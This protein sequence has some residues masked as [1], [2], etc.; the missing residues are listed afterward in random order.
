[1]PALFINSSSKQSPLGLQAGARG[2]PRTAPLHHGTG[3][4]ATGHLCPLPYRWLGAVNKSPEFLLFLSPPFLLA[5]SFLPRWVLLVP[6][7]RGCLPAQA[8]AAGG[9][10]RRAHCPAPTACSQGHSSLSRGLGQGDFAIASSW[11]SVP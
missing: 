8:F 3:S 6:A 7:S 5:N 10:E 4:G 2:R 9:T 11:G 1:M